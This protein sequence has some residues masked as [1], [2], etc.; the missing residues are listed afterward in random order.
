[1]ATYPRHKKAKILRDYFIESESISMFKEDE[2]EDTIF[3][4][5]L[6][7]MGDDKKQIVITVNDSIYLGFQ[8]L[9]AHD[10]NPEKS[11]EIL[12]VLNECNLELPTMKY[13]L[14]KDNCIVCSMFFPTEEKALQPALIMNII[15]QILKTIDQKH[16]SK[17]EEVLK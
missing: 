2:N 8:C 11:V 15:I 5:S 10:V 16:K 13:V 3:F 1:M 4:R 9:I 17:I 14:T 12:N 7:P 6:Y